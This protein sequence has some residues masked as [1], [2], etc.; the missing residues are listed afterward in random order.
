MTART[1]GRSS[2]P[3]SR[4]GMGGAPLGNLFHAVDQGTAIEAIRTAW[5]T[6]VRLFDT[7][8]HYG[9]GLSERRLGQALADLPR[10][11]FTLCTKVGRI[12]EPGPG[13]GR[14]DGGFHVPA[15]HRRR[16]DFSAAGVR[17]SLEESLDRLGMDRVDVALIHDPDD[18]MRQALDEAYPALHA[19][20][21]Q[22]TVGAIGAGMNRADTLGR[23][24]TETDIDTVLLAGRHTLLEQNA[25]P[26]LS[27][28]QDRGV[29]V[30]AA[31]VFNSGLLAQDTPSTHAT[32]NYLP[33]PAA[34][35]KRAAR[36]AEVAARHGVRL[37]QAAIAFAEAHPAVSSVVLGMRSAEEVRHNTALAALTVPTSL[38]PDLVAEG[39][40]P[41]DSVPA[42]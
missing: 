31:G 41:P 18:H 1:L 27:D 32:Y 6:G 2:V 5:E 34:L 8:P 33:A 13:R 15:D 21:A 11:S 25:A 26:L 42:A 9:L 37:P 16:W 39:L 22:G 30:L 17:R 28:C 3:V 40:L 29:S 36:L 12:L 35:R 14:D 24:V 23:F 38:W 10:G 20:R 4:I 7:A 19:L